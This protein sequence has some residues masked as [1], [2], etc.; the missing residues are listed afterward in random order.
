[1][2]I[3]QVVHGFP[4]RETAGTEQHAAAVTKAMRGRGHQLHVLA[5]T[6]APGRRAYSQL[7]EPGITRIVQNL[8]ARRLG[9]RES[10]RAMDAAAAAVCARFRPDVIHIHHLQFISSTLHFD[11]P[12]VLTLH[13]AWTWCAAGGLEL[14]PDGQPCPGPSPSRC[15]PCASAWAPVP[16]PVTRGLVGLAGRVAAWIPPEHLHRA[17]QGLP[18]RLRLQ[19]HRGDARPQ[20]PADAAAR[21]AALI[22]FARAA[23]ARTAPS[24]YL[25]RRA[26]AQG[27][28]PVRVLPHGQAPLGPWTGGGPLLFLGTVAAH[29]GPDRVVRAW[30][31][32]FPGGRPGL[33]LHGPVQDP[34]IALGHPVGPVLDRAGVR[35]ALQ[36]ASALVMGSRWPENAPLVLLEARAV[37]CPVV[38]PA[39]GGILELVEE[40]VDG[41]LYA[42][43]DEAA[44]QRCLVRVVAQP[45]GPPRPP[46]SPESQMDAYEALYAEVCR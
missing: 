5:A 12:T 3:L 40:G 1:M 7:E 23:A 33:A 35:R 8:P 45:P 44:L 17:Y 16:G 42:P 37:G 9:D 32:A 11:A 21:N 15:A 46:P 24:R 13:D 25:A 41:F 22:A 2:R 30:R 36:G 6:R 27:L 43:D 31:A 34:A 39:L 19:V 18:A 20:L 14:L 10:D 29:K 4:P 26:E 28:G 38:A